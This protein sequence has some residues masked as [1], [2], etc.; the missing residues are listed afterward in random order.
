MDLESKIDI[1]QRDVTELKVG[2]GEIRTSIKYLNEKPGGV[3]CSDHEKRLR[4]IETAKNRI[5][6]IWVL[7]ITA[8]P[9]IISIIALFINTKK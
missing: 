8:V 4:T 2:L 3:I 1:I 7:I 6:G 9:I 5:S